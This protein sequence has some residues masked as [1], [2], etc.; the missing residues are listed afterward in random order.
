MFLRLI[1]IVACLVVSGCAS[2][3]LNYNTA[4]LASSLNSLTKRQIFFNLAQALSDPEFV[5]SQATISIGTAQTLNAVTP[6][7]SIPTGLPMV[8]TARDGTGRFAGSQFTTQVTSPTPT[9][10]VQMTDGW[11]QSWTMVPLN[12]APQLRRLRA[13]YQYVTGTVPHHGTRNLTLEEAERL[14]LCEYPLQSFNVAPSSGNVTFKIE[15][16]PNNN[17]RESQSRIVHVD[18]TFTQGPTCVICIDD[19]NAKQLRPHINPNLKYNF[20]RTQK[21]GDM[22]GIG[23]HG[24]TEFYV[25]GS[26]E[27]DCPRIAQQD[28]FDGRKAFGD[29]IL[30]VYEAAT[31]PSASG[32]GRQTGGSFVYSVR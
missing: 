22:V 1:C 20:I 10:G 32:A 4:D 11:N 15:G 25:C 19:L 16:C 5:P 21:T 23:S 24:T 28:P 31:V 8:T 30:F 3:Q 26:P 12:S 2:T 17:T 13:L 18:P 29:F 6:S 27:G 14:F 7:I 9:L